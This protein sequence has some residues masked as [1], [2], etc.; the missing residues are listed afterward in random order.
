M[1]TEPDHGSIRLLGTSSPLNQALDKMKTLAKWLLIGM[2]APSA[3][4]FWPW[5][6]PSPTTT[7]QPAKFASATAPLAPSPSSPTVTLPAQKL[8]LSLADTLALLHSKLSQWRKAQENGSDDQEGQDRLVKEMLALVTDENAAEIVESF[9]AEEMN[10][11]L[12]AGALHRLMKV[13]PVEVTNWIASRAETTPAQ[14]LAVAD[15]WIGNRADLQ[16]YLNQLPDT[17]WKQNFLSDLS[18]EMSLKDPQ[19]AIKLAQQMNPGYVR[20]CSLQAVVCNWVGADPDA[21]L[22]WVAS[23]QD[24]SL[25]EQL[26]ASAVQSYAL[27]DPAQAA[28]WLLSEVKSPQVV[29]DA[30]LNILKT[31][32]VKDPAQ[33]ANWVAQFPE[34][35]TK[36]EAVQIVAQHWQQ[37]DHAA[38]TAW[39]QNL[40]RGVAIPPN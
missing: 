7:N 35:N 40:S 1:R 6:G 18:S 26:V 15:D 8:L 22:D 38:A 13:D 11:P 34:G 27:T 24:P 21:A 31:W 5:K 17:E 32:V 37:T 29:N 30:A 10:T 4:A 39:I 16:E 19:T 33:A 36:A 28:T 12:V 2:I 20:T 14:T 25:R 9:S 23:V 3:V